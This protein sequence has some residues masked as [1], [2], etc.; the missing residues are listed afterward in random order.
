MFNITDDIINEYFVT[1]L[2]PSS[3]L[4]L[5]N[6]CVFFNKRI[7]NSEKLENGKYINF[8]NLLFDNIFKK[9]HGIICCK[10]VRSLL[11][12]DIPS[13]FL[14]KFKKNFNRL[15]FQ[16]F[17]IEYFGNRKVDII[18]ESVTYKEINLEIS[19]DYKFKGN[20]KINR[21][22]II[23]KYNKKITFDLIL[24][25]YF[26]EIILLNIYLDLDCYIIDDSFSF[27]S[28]GLTIKCQIDEYNLICFDHKV[29]SNNIGRSY[30]HLEKFYV[31][32]NNID[33]RPF[34]NQYLL[35]EIQKLK[36]IQYLIEEKKLICKNSKSLM[37]GSCDFCK[38]KF[39]GIYINC[40]FKNNYCLNC[41]EKK[42][43]EKIKTIIVISKIIIV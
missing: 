2:D 8:L 33:R 9:S 3:L 22:V 10:T 34:N 21:I 6:S 19:I 41:L 27:Q 35:L 11:L 17:L 40:D 5:K 25:T 24:E 26:N 15:K 38:K 30:N 14:I 42:I 29:K 43:F 16:S 39:L 23:T 1:S 36:E 4:N 37:E 18:E 12:N 20:H 28:D 13:Y 7:S 31:K 32:W